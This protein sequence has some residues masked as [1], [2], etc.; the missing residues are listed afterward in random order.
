MAVDPLPAGIRRRSVPAHRLP[1]ALSPVLQRIYAARGAVDAGHLSL[2]LG[3]LLPPDGLLGIDTAAALLADAIARRQRIVVAGDYDADGATGVSL[4]MLGL[5][6]L[7]AASVDY[8]VPH[9][10]TMGYG[11]SPELARV[12]HGMGAQLLITVDNGIAS[13]AGVAAARELGMRVIVTDHHLPGPQL[14]AADAIINPNQP[15]CGFASKQLAG[16]GVMFYLLL[17]LRA[18]LRERGAFA[19]RPEPRLADWLDLV[20]VGTVAD[21]A[22]L[23]GNNRILV[24]QGLKRIRARR[25]R[26]GLLAMLELAGRDPAR[27]TAA[28]LGFVLGPRINAAGRL[29]DMRI[30]IECLLSPD[31]AQARPLAAALERINRER[32]EMQKLMTDEAQAQA[33]ASFS[34]ERFGVCLFDENWHEGVIGLVASKIKERTNRP[35]IAFARAQ[36]GGLLKGSARSIAGF[37]VRDAL[38]AVD[39]LQPGL[40]ERFGGHA[41]AAGLSLREDA[42]AVFSAAFDAVCRSQLA[43]DLLEAWWDSDGLLEPSQLAVETALELENA[44]PW[45]AG[46]PEPRFDGRFSVIE[47]RAVGSDGSHVKYRLRSDGRECAAID[48]GGAARLCPRGDL[49]AVYALGV[50][51]YDGRQT[52]D[53]RIEYL[54][55]V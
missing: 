28:D 31:E 29:E 45:G 41:M 50:N 36:E 15:G 4:A 21:V 38:A 1:A 19:A 9:R 24:A 55:P 53:L 54:V 27:L 32:R 20:A 12:A 13:L 39:A 2:E 25:A 6:A 5:S 23:D 10:V 46:F 49:H 26:P 30:G 18:L 33:E 35:A 11:L 37:N 40:I 7:G 16:V 52:L 14:P 3:D 42:Y 47:A 48:F 51:R 43:A 8:V 22:R 44:G 17:R 34:S